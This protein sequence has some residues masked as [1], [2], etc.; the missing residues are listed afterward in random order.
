MNGVCVCLVKGRFPTGTNQVAPGMSC[1]YNVRFLPDALCDYRD[2]LIVE[3]LTTPLVVPVH[4]SRPPPVL[5][6]ELYYLFLPV[7]TCESCC[8][9]LLF[10]NMSRNH[11]Q[12][13]TVHFAISHFAV[14]HYLTLTLSLTPP[15][16]PN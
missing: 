1:L 3:S 15:L 9:I 7:L 13:M 2:E 8:L 10:V 5:T 4:A 6:C 12:R 14:S 16:N 11:S